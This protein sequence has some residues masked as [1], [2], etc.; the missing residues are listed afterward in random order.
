MVRRVRVDGE[1]VT[2]AA[3]AFGYSRPSYYEAAAALDAAGPGRAGAGQAGPEAAAQAHRRDVRLRRQAPGR[4]SR[5]CGRRI[6]WNPSRPASACACTPARSSARWPAVGKCT[7]K[8]ADP[9]AHEPRKEDSPPPS[10]RPS[11]GPAAAEPS[12]S[13]D[14][15]Q[16]RAA[17]PVAG[18]TPATNSCVMLPCTR[19]PRH[20]R[21][22]SRCS[23]RQ[24]VT[25]WYRA[26]TQLSPPR[27]RPA[28][29]PPGADT[30]SVAAAMLPAPITA[31]LVDALAAVV[32]AGT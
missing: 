26:L 6:W 21:S 15:G 31:E 30:A 1:S 29:L 12:P 5:A 19:V 3:A 17:V 9:P 13:L 2:S 14:A 25:A 10:P 4:R 27:A 7:P 11:P 20:S 28:Q 32:L 16:D 22:A 8:A 23:P 24:G 18:S